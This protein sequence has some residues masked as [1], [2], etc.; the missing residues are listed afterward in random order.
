MIEKNLLIS[1]KKLPLEFMGRLHALLEEFDCQIHAMYYPDCAV[2]KLSIR[3]EINSNGKIPQESYSTVD[4]GK[5][6]SGTSSEVDFNHKNPGIKEIVEG[7]KRTAEEMAFEVKR[8]V[9]G[10]ELEKKAWKARNFNLI[11]DLSEERARSEEKN[12]KLNYSESAMER[13]EQEVSNLQM[14]YADLLKRHEYSGDVLVALLACTRE[15][16]KISKERPKGQYGVKPTSLDAAVDVISMCM[17]RKF[18]PES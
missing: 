1:D 2:E 5:W 15:L 17:G 12:E 6:I 8:L 14:S 3:F 9:I 4:V 18:D 16:Y 11:S 13:L 7:C 10:H